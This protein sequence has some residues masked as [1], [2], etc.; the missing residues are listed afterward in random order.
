M[1]DV[2]QRK[3]ALT[4]FTPEE[5]LDAPLTQTSEC[6]LG[7]A[8]R[9]ARLCV[10]PEVSRKSEC[11]EYSIREM[12][13]AFGAAEVCGGVPELGTILTDPT[14]VQRTKFWREVA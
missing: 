4:P 2:T 10:Y 7:R 14:A 3:G 13:V 5:L 6:F 1:T 11:D 12:R 8:R 9:R